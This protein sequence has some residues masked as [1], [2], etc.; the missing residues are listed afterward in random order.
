[1][2]EMSITPKI[3]IRDNTVFLGEVCSLSSTKGKKTRSQIKFE[4]KTV[5]NV[6]VIQHLSNLATQENR[7]ETT[8]EMEKA[9]SE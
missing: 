7:S 3:K 8:M 4:E 2:R 9:L 5:S 6:D 1:M